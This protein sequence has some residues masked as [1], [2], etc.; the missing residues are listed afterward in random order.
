MSAP[1][2]SLLASPSPSALAVLAAA[3]A[4]AESATGIIVG[5]ALLAGAAAA[6]SLDG[7]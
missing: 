1:H 2:V 3:E 6:P 4:S 5:V 7:A